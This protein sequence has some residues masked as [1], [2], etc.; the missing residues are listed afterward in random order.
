MILLN[1]TTKKNKSK[2]LVEV[3]SESLGIK[4]EPK[5]SNKGDSITKWLRITK[6]NYPAAWCGSFV[7]NKLLESGSKPLILSARAAAYRAKNRCY[8]LSDVIYNNYEIKP[9]DL[10]VKSRV[11]GNHVDIFISWNQTKKSGYVIGGNVDDKVQI[12]KVTIQSM[13]N[14]R[15]TDIVSINS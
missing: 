7:G 15:T 1:S 3:A 11:G 4:E 14:D 6:I 13:I 9:G 2:L 5:G 8:K 12:R 10:R